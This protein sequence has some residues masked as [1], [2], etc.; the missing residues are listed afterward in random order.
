MLEEV[1]SRKRFNPYCRSRP[2]PQI[3]TGSKLPQ[4]L[5]A[6]IHHLPLPK[7]LFPNSETRGQEAVHSITSG[8][9]AVLI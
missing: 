2:G 8:S 9:G 7:V 5:K 4:E 1:F 3:Y 6:A